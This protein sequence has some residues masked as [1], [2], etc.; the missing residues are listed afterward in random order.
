MGTYA[1][2]AA[3]A[4]R[5]HGLVARWQALAAGIPASTFDRLVGPH[6]ERVRPAVY[7]ILGAPP[8]REQRLLAACLAAGPDAAVSHRAAACSWELV[9]G[10]HDVV[11]IVTPRRQAILLR[12]VTVHR[13]KDLR[14]DHV[15][16]RSGVPTTNPMRTL[17]DLGAVCPQPIVAEALERGLVARLFSIVAVESMVFD[18][19]QRGRDGV[20]VLRRVLDSRALRAAGPDGLLEPRMARL[21]RR[22]DL[23]QAVFQLVVR[24][25][26][27]G[28]LA[29]VDF[30]Y[31]HLKLAIEVDGFAVH[32]TPEAMAADF[33]RQNALHAAGWRVIR[34]TWHQVVRRPREV[35]DAI[36]AVLG[37]TNVA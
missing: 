5:Q 29:R 19:A 9:E 16:Y 34:F 24:D 3:I 23:P 22:Y 10:E 21:L 13:S 32:G 30:A 36:R 33:A 4:A 17:V 14:A 25:E 20:G 35:A 6:L 11:E 8:S 27:G 26:R 7:R 15:T 31:P 28:F 1:V 37:S 2:V 12:N 18:V